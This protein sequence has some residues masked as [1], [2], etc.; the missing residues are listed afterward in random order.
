MKGRHKTVTEIDPVPEEISRERTGGAMAGEKNGGHL[1][2]ALLGTP[3]VKV[4]GRDLTKRIPRKKSLVLLAYLAM[5]HSRPHL[6]KDLAFLL[7]PDLPEDRAD[8]SLRQSLYSLRKVLDLGSPDAPSPLLVERLSVRLNPDVFFTTDVALLVEPAPPCSAFHPPD[9]CF[10]CDR[11]LS[12]GVGHIRGPFMEGFDLPESDDFRDWVTATREYCQMKALRAVDQLSRLRES[13]GRSGDA[14]SLLARYLTMDPLDESQHRRLIELHLSRGDRR[15]AE[16]QYDSCRRTLRQLLGVEPEKKT[17]DLYER[18]RTKAP[19]GPSLQEQALPESIPDS[20]PERRPVTILSVECLDHVAPDEEPELPPAEMEG[21]LSR[22]METIRSLGGIP[23]RTH[24]SA[25]LAYF[26]VEEMQEGAARRTARAALEIS[27]D[28]HSVWKGSFRGA[29]HS[30]MAIVFPSGQSP[31]DPMG[32]VS[33]PATSLCMQAEPGTF[34]VSE[35]AA[36][37]LKGQF[38]LEPAGLFRISGRP[39]PAFRLTG[40]SRTED[41]EDGERHPPLI[42]RE[43]ELALFRTLFEKGTID[44]LLVTGDPG[45]GKS[46][47]LREWI[48]GLPPR[49]GRGRQQVT[50]LPHYIDSPYF[51]L[52]HFLRGEAEIPEGLEEGVAYTRLLRF[53]RSLD[54]EDPEKSVTLLAPLL[55]LAPHPDFPPSPSPNTEKKEEI[56]ELFCLALRRRIAADSLLVVEDFHW[57]DDSTQTLLRRFLEGRRWSGEGLVVLTCRS[58]ELPGWGATLE[59]TQKIELSPL[60]DRHG[61]KLVESLAHDGGLPSEVIERIVKN[62]DGV[63]LFLEEMTRILTEGTAVQDPIPNG[64]PRIPA[65]LSEVL[66]DRLNRLPPEIRLLLQKASVIGRSVPMD[67]FRRV[68][69]EPIPR[70]E[71]LLAEAS[72]SGLILQVSGQS[73]DSFEFRHSLIQETAYQSMIRQERQA[74][75]GHVAKVMEDHFSK[76]AMSLPGVVAL[77]WTAAERYPQAVEWSEKAARACLSGGSYSEAEH[78]ARRALSLCDRLL[79]AQKTPH[80]RIRLLVLLGNILVERFGYGSKEAR[81]VFHQAASLCSPEG[82]VPGNL[83]PALLGLWHSSLGGDDLEQSRK[84]S[85]TLG[86]I[87][88]RSESIANH[89]V[90]LYASGCVL[91]W[92]GDFPRSMDRLNACRDAYTRARLGGKEWSGEISFEEVLSMALS[93]RPW[94]LWFLGRYVSA[95]RELELVLDQARVEE[96][97][98]KRGLLLSFACTGF[99]YLRLPDRVLE[100]ADELERHVRLTRAEGWAPVAQAFRGWAWAIKGDPQGIP[101]ILRS[102]PLWRRAHRM[103]ES[104]Y[105]SL[106]AEAYLSLGDSKRALGVADSAL[107]FSRKSGTGFYDAELWRIRGESFLLG[108]DQEEARRCYTLSLETGRR[109]GARA[110]KLRTATSLGQLLLNQQKNDEAILTI[111]SLGD[112]LFGS[113]ADLSLPD[114]R[115]ASEMRR[116]LLGRNVILHPLNSVTARRERDRGRHSYPPRWEPLAKDR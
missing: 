53:L 49:N 33:R 82:K 81:C 8:H 58:G 85:E 20:P 80:L 4:D 67:L 23:V 51:P 10:R 69:G 28:C 115:D 18:I 26:G 7:W 63:P 109:Q 19:Q 60:S 111:S 30:G 50:C 70:L 65:T 68:S 103:V 42:G 57:S 45:I 15:S 3:V 37:L 34:L 114:L 75:H 31:A 22:A 104:S 40:V 113:E 62:S 5:E 79:D 92:K 44:I 71:R 17:Q 72:Q 61:R 24:G 47:L 87:A 2:L 46:R 74:L 112:L 102:L 116:R 107:S 96:G 1:H 83:F 100:V 43:K 108:G 56:E 6:R 25:F 27:K 66:F 41:G 101:L 91:F 64:R 32:T 39:V 55:F 38:R 99:R 12:E 89:A 77:H 73:E 21:R 59:R 98:Q 29:I 94:V 84:L 11:R 95:R 13:Q 106:L 35:A 9:R 54:L 48:R 14:I 36:S 97:R 90:S 52:I 105:L 88:D 93:Y 86:R 76:R 78:H 110:L 16:V